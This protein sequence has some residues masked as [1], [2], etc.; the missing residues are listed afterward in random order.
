MVSNCLCYEWL[1]CHRWSAA[2]PLRTELGS[3]WME[4][5]LQHIPVPFTSDK[6]CDIFAFKYFMNVNPLSA[7]RRMLMLARGEAR[8][9]CWQRP[10][11][12]ASKRISWRQLR[13]ATFRNLQGLWIDSW[14]V[15]KGRFLMDYGE[16]FA[17]SFAI[18]VLKYTIFK[19]PVRKANYS[20]YFPIM[21]QQGFAYTYGSNY[22]YE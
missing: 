18:F 9:C 3:L 1:C 20:W 14:I 6:K 16:Q 15:P 22:T 5:V 12:Q 2:I 8:L 7:P 4:E 13:A 19:L 10:Q 17:A 11:C 21:H